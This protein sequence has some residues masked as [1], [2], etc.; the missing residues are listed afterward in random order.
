VTIQVDGVMVPAPLI[1]VQRWAPPMIHP[2]PRR[3][4]AC[5]SPESLARVMNPWKAY[6]M[7]SVVWVSCTH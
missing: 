2:R 3:P 4:P 5:Q 7:G 6:L 1:P